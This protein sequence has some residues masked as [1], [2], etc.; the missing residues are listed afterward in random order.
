MLLV[1]VA[2]E[3]HDVLVGH[4]ELDR[5]GAVGRRPVPLRLQVE[6]GPV[7]QH[8]DAIVGLAL[9]EIGGK[10]GELLVAELGRR[11]GDVV[12]S[13]EVH[14]LVVEGVVRGAEELLVG[15]AAVER[16]V[17]LARHEAHVLHRERR[18]DLAEALHALAAD[19]GIVGGMGEIAGED[20]EV[21]LLG[22]A[23]HGGH[24]LLQRV[25]GIGIC[26]PA[27]TPVRVGELHEMEVAGLG[28]SLAAREE[29]GGEGDTG[30]A[31]KLEEIAAIGVRHGGLPEN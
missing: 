31:G 29:P 23:V 2:V 30:K 3:H 9:L 22:Q 21:R 10:P 18:D 28:A 5:L 26:S 6:Q 16:G 27:V 25:L 4:Q 15:L 19:L 7:G 12:E 13:D 17:V 24:R 1:D 14:A 11:V 20:D 8:D